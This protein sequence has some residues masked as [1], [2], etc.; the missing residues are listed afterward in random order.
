MTRRRR[1]GRRTHGTGHLPAVLPPP[2]SVIVFVRSSSGMV[3]VLADP[4][5]VADYP[6]SMCGQRITARV[7]ED[8]CFPDEFLHEDCLDAFPFERQDELFDHSEPEEQEA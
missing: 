4:D 3:H 8:G 2:P 6:L 1:G 5:E 7:I